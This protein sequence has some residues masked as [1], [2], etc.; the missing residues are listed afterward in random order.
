MRYA[1]FAPGTSRNAEEILNQPPADAVGDFDGHDS[2]ALVEVHGLT[3][4]F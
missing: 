4:D 3:S 2:T 1:L